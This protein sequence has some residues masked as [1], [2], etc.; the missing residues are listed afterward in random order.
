MASLT[1]NQVIHTSHNL[2]QQI[3]INPAIFNVK[4]FLQRV[5]CETAAHVQSAVADFLQTACSVTR[6]HGDNSWRRTIV[7]Q[8]WIRQNVFEFVVTVIFRLE[9]LFA[10]KR[11]FCIC[12][13]NPKKIRSNEKSRFDSDWQRVTDHVPVGYSTGQLIPVQTIRIQQFWFFTKPGKRIQNHC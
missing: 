2:F 6:H 4:G 5:L 10:S 7:I 12:G 9:T 13:R 8:R 11:D 3:T 1:N